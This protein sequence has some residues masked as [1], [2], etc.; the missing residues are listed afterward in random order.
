MDLHEIDLEFMEQEAEE[1]L[2]S[3]E[4]LLLGLP[5]E[6]DHLQIDGDANAA[7]LAALD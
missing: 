7:L 1:R 5:S 6:A 2:T 3:R 4:A